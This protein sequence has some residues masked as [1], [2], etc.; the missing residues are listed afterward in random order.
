[1][2]Q[3]IVSRRTVRSNRVRQVGP[4]GRDQSALSRRRLLKGGAM[5]LL[6]GAAPSLIIPERARAQQKTLK[7][8]RWKHFVPSFEQ[9]F[10]ETYIKEWGAKKDTQVIV[11]N[12]GTADI[13][14]RAAAEAEV[15]RGHDLVLMLKPVAGFEDHVIDHREIYD[16]CNR[17][18]GPVPEF[19]TKSTYNPRTRKYFAFC[20]A[21]QAAMLT[22]RK[23]LWDAVGAAPESWDD[24]LSGARWIKLLHGS[25]VGFSLAPEDNSNWTMR[26]IMYGFG[27]SEQDADGNPA[28]KSKATLEAIKYLKALYDEAMTEDVL[29]WDHTSNNRFMLNGEGCLTLDAVS[30][31]RASESIKLPI[32]SDLQLAKIPQGPEARLGPAFGLVS[33]LI[34]K[35]SLNID[36]AK[37]FLVDYVAS[38]REAFLASQF[39]NAPGFQE[40]VPDLAAL[41]ANDPVATPP[42]KYS[43]LTG[44]TSWTTNIGHP[45]YTNAAISETFHAGLIPR[46]FARAATGRLTPEEALDQ[47]DSEVRRMF[48]KW[49]ERG[50]V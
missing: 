9:W 50:K 7:I 24:I 4:S 27:S 31:T 17:R 46:M 12:V 3:M 1:M 48:Q 28:L 43:L 8:L 33:S 16:E 39:Q 40:A 11:E 13:V 41:V 42:D 21:Y 49:Q 19:A 10:T 35:F 25:P 14:S 22:Y 37:Q 32:E 47:A 6:A 5:A 18:Y 29:K 30:I 44:A 34:W 15:Q 2:S 23:D 36:G 45:G 26:T 38:S 20:G